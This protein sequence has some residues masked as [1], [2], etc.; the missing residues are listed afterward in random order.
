MD[1]IRDNPVRESEGSDIS[2]SSVHT[3]DLS[4]FEDSDT[5]VFRQDVTCDRRRLDHHGGGNAVWLRR[6]ISDPVLQPF[7]RSVGPTSPLGVDATPLEYFQL[8][9]P[10]QMFEE[11]SAQTNLYAQQKHRDHFVNTSAAEVSAFL[12]VQLV[13]GVVPDTIWQKN[14]IQL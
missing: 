9:F 3:S 8:Y 6:P 1:F 11:F 7:V 10:E 5:G 4:D 12:G 2:V 13:M 14:S